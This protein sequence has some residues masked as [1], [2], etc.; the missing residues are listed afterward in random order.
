MTVSYSWNNVDLYS[1]LFVQLN[2]TD[3]CGYKANI[4]QFNNKIDNVNNISRGAN[5]S[6]FLGYVLR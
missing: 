1:I 2:K 5:F 3:V 4:A 6:V